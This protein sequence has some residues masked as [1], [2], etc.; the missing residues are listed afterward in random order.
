VRAGLS[1]YLQ[2]G[3]TTEGTELIVEPAARRRLLRAQRTEDLRSE[4]GWAAVRDPRGGRVVALIS[5]SREVEAWV[6]GMDWGTLGAHAGAY[7]NLRLGPGEQRGALSFL[8]LA[9]DEDEARAYRVLAGAE[10][11]P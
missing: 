3:G 10:D 7:C 4:D 6:E 5:G 1:A 11:L 2:P 8:V 9:Q